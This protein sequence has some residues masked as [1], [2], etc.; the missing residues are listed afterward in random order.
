MS[1]L[2]V[3]CTR[4]FQQVRPAPSEVIGC[5]AVVIGLL[6]SGQNL[7]RGGCLP[8]VVIYCPRRWPAGGLGGHQPAGGGYLP[9]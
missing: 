2:S 3:L 8:L 4:Q 9:P 1:V 6:A 7:P 5:A